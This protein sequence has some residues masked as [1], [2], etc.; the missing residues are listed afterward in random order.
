MRRVVVTGMGAV[1]PLGVGV[2]R[3]WTQLMAA[4]SGRVRIQHFDTSDLPCRIAGSV[5]RGPDGFDPLSVVQ[6]KQLRH[7]DELIVFALAAAEQAA[8]AAGLDQVTDEERDRIGVLIGSGIAGVRM[9]A[10]NAVALHERG[11]RRISPYF[12]PGSLINEAS[13]A[14]SSFMSRAS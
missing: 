1:T 12:I 11:P 8:K 10:D 2:E 4:K 6:S 7:M 14:V 5:P 3:L 9:I 13:G